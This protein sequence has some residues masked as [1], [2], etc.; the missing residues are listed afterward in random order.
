[1]WAKH[2]HTRISASTWEF[3]FRRKWNARLLRNPAFTNTA[4]IQDTSLHT[5]TFPSLSSCRSFT[6]LE[7][8]IRESQEFLNSNPRRTETFPITLFPFSNLSVICLFTFSNL[9]IS[10][11]V[12][13]HLA[14]QHCNFIHSE[15]VACYDEMSIDF[16]FNIWVFIMAIHISVMSCNELF[17][18]LLSILLSI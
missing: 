11:K 2:V 6:N 17:S 16:P 9:F 8:H 1:M 7:L 5:T 13:Y 3:R 10:V 12:A 18:F 14:W 15:D 4:T